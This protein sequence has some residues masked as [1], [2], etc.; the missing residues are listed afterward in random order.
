VTTMGPP[1]AVLRRSLLCNGTYL[2]QVL[3]ALAA[4]EWTDFRS[5]VLSPVH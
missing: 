2:D 3:R 4:T 5:T 1:E